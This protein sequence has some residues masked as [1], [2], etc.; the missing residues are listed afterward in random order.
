[1]KTYLYNNHFSGLSFKKKSISGALKTGVSCDLFIF[2]ECGSTL[3]I[4][5]VKPGSTTFKVQKD[6]YGVQSA[7]KALLGSEGL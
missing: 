6:G 1:M 2:R 5:Y 4:G 3:Y 7:A